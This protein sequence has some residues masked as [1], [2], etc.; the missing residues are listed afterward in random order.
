MYIH[1]PSCGDGLVELCP[2]PAALPA[3]SERTY[4]P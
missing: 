2:W 3:I 1:V 4:T